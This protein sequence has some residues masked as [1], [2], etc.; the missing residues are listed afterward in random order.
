MSKDYE[1]SSGNVFADLGLPN[2]EHELVKAKLTVQIFRV[3]RARASPDEGGRTARHDAITG[4]EPYALPSCRHLYRSLDG[5]SN[6][7]RPGCRS[8]GKANRAARMSVNVQPS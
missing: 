3:L 8:D 2:P 1:N 6:H 5:I 4:L 7:F